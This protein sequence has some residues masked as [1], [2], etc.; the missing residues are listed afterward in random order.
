MF[1]KT[2]QILFPSRVEALLHSALSFEIRV[3]A[4]TKRC[5]LA[6]FH[7]ICFGTLA[8]ITFVILAAT[9]VVASVA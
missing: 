6:V 1:S 8:T 7:L 5:V 2:F 3:E 9:V 4:L